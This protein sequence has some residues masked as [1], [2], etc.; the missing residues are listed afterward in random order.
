MITNIVEDYQAFLQG[1]VIRPE[2]IGFDV[3]DADI[4]PILKPHQ[5]AIVRWALKGGR[6]AI[7]A[8]F[9]LGKS[10]IQL[11]I[12]RLAIAYGGGMGLLVIPLGVRQEFMRDAHV[13]RTGD[14][15]AITDAQR[16]EL[17]Q[18]LEGR[19]D[20]APN[21]KF[22]R[23]I[24]EAT[25]PLGMYA[26]NYETVRD[27]KLDP[28]LFAV[29]SLDE[30]SCLRGFGGTKTFRE[31]MGLFA[32]DYKTMDAR[33]RSDGVRY[34][35]VAT[36][37]PSP[38]DYIELLAY[39]AFLGV[40]DVSAAKTR[41]FKRNSEKADELTIHAHKEREFWL[42]V[43]SWGLF[44]QRPSDLGFDDAGYD[45]PALDVRWHEIPAD[46]SEA[47][48]E[49]YGQARMFKSQALGVVDAAREKRD[50]LPA[51]IAKMM[52]L[53]AED[54]DAHR[55]IW[56]D[57]EA[58]RHA[59]ERAIPTV[60]SVY[61]SQDLDEREA[62]IIKF[63]DGQC[64]ELAAKPVI[65]GSGCNFQRHCHWAI[66]LGIGFKFNDL[67]QAIHRLQ[68]FLQQDTVRIDLIYTEAERGVRRTME[69]KWKQHIQMMEKMSKI[70]KE[71]GLTEDA[72]AELLT[73]S[74][75]V[76]R[77]ESAGEN[78]R[79]I[80]NDSVLETAKLAENSVGFILTSIP[81]STQYEYSPNYADFG[82][83]DNNEHFFG[84]MDYLTP[85]LFKS[86]QPGRIAAIHVKDRIV[87][88][89][90]TGLGFQ[91]VYP[92]HARCIEHFTK[93]GFAYMG[94]KTIVTDVVRENNQTYR[95][96]WTEQCKD[97]SKM[98]CGMP[99]YLLLFRKPPTDT[100][101][102]YADMPVVKQKET[103]S[104][105]RWQVDA[106]GYARS[107]GNRH[108]TPEELQSMPHDQIFKAFRNYSLQSVYDFD[109]HV[110]IG[111][112]L[113]TQ[114]KLPVTFMLLQPQS[115]STEVWAD[116][117]RMLTLNGA[118]SAKGKEMH[119]CPMQ[120]DIADR[121]I[122]Q[123]SMPGETVLDPFGGLM[124]VPYRA[125]LKG[126]KGVGIELNPSYFLDGV[127][128]CKAAEREMSMPSLFDF[129][130]I[131]AAA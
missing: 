43:S 80:N 27:G 75:G 12:V 71:Y 48:H 105:A 37:T 114:G 23:S 77:I 17:A 90:M 126:R 42:W 70:I 123:F 52:E 99:E 8:A 104:R 38:N 98:S 119:L 33:V 36:A 45:M 59:I 112:S 28:R 73:R 4:N 88:G 96:G 129:E 127:A 47:G 107:S 116:V 93:H 72:M 69:R 60:A 91:T 35:F 24:A 110:K 89:G 63:S 10:I 103:Y 11:E 130:E 13:L 44:V 26:T 79:C 21:P 81:F 18:W 19:P 2:S 55:I 115:W 86:L 61:G 101:N 67:I 68:R 62:T 97:G 122:E 124:T 87:P 25:D 22:I 6:R 3:A 131:G 32:G 111:E 14:H 66:F 92:F 108:L 46:H 125:V 15:P 56:H 65:A 102:S 64:Q 39:S 41:F 49:V 34:R 20:R 50:S 76:E 117:T 109:H 16:A 30:A 51:R 7:F 120:F 58:E 54:P 31:F 100:S 1:K 85:N 82:H 78:Y 53:R 95:L 83:T 121:A 74:M 118:Q 29:A 84:Q 113:D 57:L 106:H 9:G 94:M 128:Y 5:R 40:M